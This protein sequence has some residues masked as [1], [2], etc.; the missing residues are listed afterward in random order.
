MNI[1]MII[2][3]IV[4]VTVL[5]LLYKLLLGNKTAVVTNLKYDKVLDPYNYSSLTTPNSTRYSYYIWI[6]VNSIDPIY[7][8]TFDISG[9]NIFQLKDTKSTYGNDNILFSLDI[10]KSTNLI[11]SVTTM[12]STVQSVKVKQNTISTNFPMQSWQQVIISFDN[13]HM[14]YYLNGK[15]VKS[16]VFP[17]DALPAMSTGTASINFGT[18]TPDINVKLFDRLDY[19]MD[20]QTAWN[21][22]LSDYNTGSGSSSVNYGLH[23]NLSSSNKTPQKFTIF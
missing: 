17:N 12:N 16:V 8:S 19:P 23:L 20:P 22:Y 1:K 10:F 3:G 2:L 15:F 9:E 18:N 5:F 11:A 6:Y 21:K 7:A 13:N 4:M 14:D